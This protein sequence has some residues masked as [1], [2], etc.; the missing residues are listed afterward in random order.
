M[1]EVTSRDLHAAVAALELK[2]GD[3]V[4]ISTRFLSF[5]EAGALGQ[6]VPNWPFDRYDEYLLGL[7][8]LT[9]IERVAP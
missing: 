2:P 1:I 5:R 4:R 8:A 9:S 3:R 6:H 7:H